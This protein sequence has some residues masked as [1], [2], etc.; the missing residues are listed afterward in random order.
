MEIHYQGTDITDMVQVKSCIVHDTCGNRCDS[1][2]IVFE[3]AAGWYSWGPEEDDQ[4]IVS[5]D[6]YESGIMY[7]NMI[8]PQEGKYRILATSLPCK[9]RGKGYKSYINQTIG[10]IIHSCAAL[11][12]M[13]SQVFGLD[14]NAVIPYIERN[15]EGCPAFLDRLLTME[16]AALK[17]VNGKYTAIGIDYAQDMEPISTVALTAKQTGA[18][19]TRNGMARKSLTIKTP[20]AEATAE[21]T[22]VAEMHA[23]VKIHDIPALNNIQAGR[24]ARGKLLNINRNC[25]SVEIK[26]DFN[27]DYTAMIRINIDG[28]TDATGEWLIDE[29]THDLINLQ[30][31]AKM[32]RCIRTIR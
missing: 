10:D 16:G 14:A 7:L 22:A 1:M 29:V 24:W 28:D 5:H 17:C 19:Y 25:E 23:A 30:T 26:S 9:A 12:S 13:E 6:G 27:P 18:Q 2:D 20:Y 8:M 21:D 4:I 11:S 15:N 31:T 3:N 32:K